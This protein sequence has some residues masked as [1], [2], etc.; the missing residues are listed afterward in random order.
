[1]KK[2]IG[3][4]VPPMTNADRIRAMS[5]EELAA[6][7]AILTKYDVCINPGAMGCDDCPFSVFCSDCKE[8]Q[9]LEWLQQPV[10]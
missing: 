2:L 3:S 10:E 9:E 4:F 8:G 7:L 1:M 6:A 5:D